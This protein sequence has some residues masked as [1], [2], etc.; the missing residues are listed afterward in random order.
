[1]KKYELLKNE[2]LSEIADKEQKL[3]EFDVKIDDVR[4]QIN[5]CNADIEKY[6]KELNTKEYAKARA[7]REDFIIQLEMYE[8]SKSLF[9]ESNNTTREEAQSFRKSINK[10]QLDILEN[11]EKEIAGKLAE[12][13]TITESAI[14]DIAAGNEI[15]IE[16]HEKVKNFEKHVGYNGADPVYIIDPE[17]TFSLQNRSLSYVTGYICNKS[18]DRIFNT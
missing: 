2:M 15:L 17:I 9:E 13:K 1:M 10:I 18:T 16:Y 8:K 6:T 4:A 12:I 11:A 14:N 7:K 5:K 3:N